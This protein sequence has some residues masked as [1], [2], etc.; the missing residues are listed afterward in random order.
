VP[1]TDQIAIDPVSVAWAVLIATLISTVAG[2]APT[3]RAGRID[4]QTEL[5]SRGALSR[6]SATSGWWRQCLAVAQ[7]ALMLVL[8]TISGLLLRSFWH[9]QRADLGFHASDVLTATVRFYGEQYRLNPQLVTEFQERLLARVRALPGVVEAG[10]TTG[11]PL[12]AAW[13][14]RPTSDCRTPVRERWRADAKWI[15]RFLRF[16]AFSS[17]TAGTSMRPIPRRARVWR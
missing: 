16:S 5:Q 12:S 4:I 11:L 17:S 10:L 6:S 2:L 8:L 1:R 9:L 7:I 3:W 15:H 13:I 14:N